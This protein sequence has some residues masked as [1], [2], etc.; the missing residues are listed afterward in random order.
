MHCEEK[1]IAL[2]AS[3]DKKRTDV[4][5]ARFGHVAMGTLNDM[6]ASERVFGLPKTVSSKVEDACVG[7][8]R[9]RWC[10]VHSGRRKAVAPRDHSSSFTPMWGPMSGVSLGKSRYFILFIDDYTKKTFVR[11]MSRKSEVF[12]CFKDFV[13]RAE[14]QTGLKVKL[15]RSDNGGKY[16]NS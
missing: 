7:C 6:A 15:L 1:S 8:V 5:H 2:S 9:G 12:S 13:R 10:E 4:W 11:F 14:V 16:I 3:E